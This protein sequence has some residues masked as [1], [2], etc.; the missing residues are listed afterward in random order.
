MTSVPGQTREIGEAFN[1]LNREIKFL[2]G[3]KLVRLGY[4]SYNQAVYYY[5]K[6]VAKAFVFSFLRVRTNEGHQGVFH[7]LFF[8]QFIPRMW[9]ADTW[10]RLLGVERMSEHSVDIRECRQ[11][12]RSPI[13][14]ARYCVS[15]YVAG[16]SEY[17]KFYQSSG[18]LYKG[19][20]DDYDACR[21]HYR[22]YGCI[23]AEQGKEGDG[24]RFLSG[25]RNFWRPNGYFELSFN[26]YWLEYCRKKVFKQVVFTL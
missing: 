5:G 22:R 3:E 7:V 11:D 1:L 8:G 16:Q 12:V 15:Q 25:L 14:L 13:R 24:L 26:D 2:T 21:V 9:I 10:Q 6:N 18:W 19:W 23:N 20:K 4:L 17:I